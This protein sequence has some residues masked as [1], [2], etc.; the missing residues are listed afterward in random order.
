MMKRFFRSLA[1]SLALSLG[2]L[3]ASAHEDVVLELKDG[4]LVAPAAEGDE[5]VPQEFLP[6][7]YDAATHRVRIG[8][9][10]MKMCE[11]FASLFPD[12]GKYKIR[13][14]SSW[15]HD[16]ETLPPYLL[17]R[18][19]P[20]GRQFAYELLLNMKDL[21]VISLTVALDLG[22]GSSRDFP[23][24]LSGWEEEIQKSIKTVD[25]K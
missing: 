16:S 4:K 5:K 13:F 20:E 11:Y 9:H 19:E 25:G 10:E 12:D 2:C 15:Y 18:I 17:I 7:E 21:S 23:V 24:D 1:W 14:S 6:M 3:T 8:K 22:G